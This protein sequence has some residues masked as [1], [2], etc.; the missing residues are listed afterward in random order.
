[1]QHCISHGHAVDDGIEFAI[2]AVPDFCPD[3]GT[4]LRV[5][6]AVKAFIES[7]NRAFRWAVEV[8]R[9]WFVSWRRWFHLG[10]IPNR[11]WATATVLILLPVHCKINDSIAVLA[12]VLVSARLNAMFLLNHAEIRPS[13]TDSGGGRSGL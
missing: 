6:I 1:M 13:M 5:R 7:T 10:G 9:M 11:D 4:L 12:P 8:R 2:V 3:F